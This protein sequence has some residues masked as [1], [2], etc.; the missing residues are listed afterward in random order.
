[1]LL[2][3]QRSV[4]KSFQR[5]HNPIASPGFNDDMKT[6]QLTAATPPSPRARILNL[7]SWVLGGNL[8]AQLLRLGSSLVLTRL[9]VPECFGLMAA[10]N[11]LY[12]GLLM[13]SDLG[14]WQS[15]VRSE[16]GDDPRF[17]GTAWL[18]QILRGLLLA[19]FVLLLALLVWTGAQAGWFANGTVYA[20]PRLPPMMAA[21]SLSAILQGFESIR[22]ATAQRE[23][24]GAHVVGLEL[25]A[26]I[27]AI[28]ITVALAWYTGSVWALMVGTIAASAG[29]TVL[30]H[31]V[32]HSRGVSPCWD[33]D[34]FRELFGYGKWLFVS[35]IFGYLG[36][37]GEKLILGASLGAA[38][39]GLFA[40][41]SNLVSAAVGLYGAMNARVVFPGLSAARR[42]GDSDAARRAFE[43]TQPFVDLCLGFVGGV[44]LTA[45]GAIVTLLYD[46]RYTDAGW[47]LQV[48]GLG[49]VAMRHQAAEQLMFCLGHPALVSANNAM[50]AFMLCVFIPAGAAMGGD[51]GAV[52]G[53]TLSQV[54]S[55]PLSLCFKHR[56]G[57]LNWRT[58]GWWLPALGAGVLA[59]LAL[60]ALL[61]RWV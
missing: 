49:L 30:S 22:L 2:R 9:L 44:L 37:H 1:M 60:D 54:A 8:S 52:W 21:L 38:T 15:V 5:R 51:A 4:A 29:K 25:V 57:V 12:F 17:L 27:L 13:L 26:Q 16:R 61:A 28:T 53:V 41:A 40:I 34:S 42:D 31:A 36:A 20:D 39:F 10:I 24:K 47:M 32:L 23:M 50:R 33:R 3:L 56:Q 43:R 45:G 46:D 48:L 58:E 11:A 59:G 19:L 14:V 18:L 35:S 6:F 55:W 7:A